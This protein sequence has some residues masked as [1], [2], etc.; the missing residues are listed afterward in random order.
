MKIKVGD[1][2]RVVD[3]IHRITPFVGNTGEVK[4]ISHGAKHPYCVQFLDEV[5]HSYSAW[6]LEKVEE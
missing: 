3:G 6:E 4:F 1:K 5:G 2:V